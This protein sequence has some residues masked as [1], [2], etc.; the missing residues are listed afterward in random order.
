MI[1]AKE[2]AELLF[3]HNGNEVEWEDKISTETEQ[4]TEET[5]SLA[6]RR[7]PRNQTK[8]TYHHTST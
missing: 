6:T 1:L 4:M 2:K 8:V 3:Q 5:E 7:T